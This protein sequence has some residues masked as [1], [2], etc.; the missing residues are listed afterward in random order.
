MSVTLVK[1]PLFFPGPERPGTAQL[2]G[3]YEHPKSEVPLEHEISFPAEG[4]IYAI[5][6]F[7]AL[8][9]RAVA[10]LHLLFVRD[11]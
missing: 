1:N 8:D 7:R 3:F 5:V 6:S 2:S 9:F 11:T 4:L 10:S